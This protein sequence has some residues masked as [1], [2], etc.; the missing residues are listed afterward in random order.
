MRLEICFLLFDFRFCYIDCFL[1]KAISVFF[2]YSRS[3]A[4]LGFD[5]FETSVAIFHCLLEFLWLVCGWMMLP[6]DWVLL[7]LE[8]SVWI[9][10]GWFYFSFCFEIAASYDNPIVGVQ[11]SK[12]FLTSEYVIFGFVHI[13]W[14]SFSII[15]FSQALEYEMIFFTIYTTEC[16]ITT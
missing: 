15:Y 12:N 8:Y 9:A 4:V 16:F 3:F 7:L 1:F 13:V 14:I 10:K 5:E 2:L 11:G 6:I